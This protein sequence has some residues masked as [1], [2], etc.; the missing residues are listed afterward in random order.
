MQRPLCVD[1]DGT[2]IKSDLSYELLIKFILQKPV[3]FLLSLPYAFNKAYL[4]ERLATIY[5]I[6]PEFLPYQ[7][8][9]LDFLSKQENRE[10]ILV[11]GSHE[12]YAKQI[13][14]HLNL[15]GWAGTTKEINLIGHNKAK[16]L[17]D[18]YGERNFDY[19]GNSESDVPVWKK[20]HTSYS[21]VNK[22]WGIEGMQHIAVAKKSPWLILFKLLRVHQWSKNALV[23]LPM[24]LGFKLNLETL[25]EGILAFFSFSFIASAVYIMNDLLDIENDRKHPSKRHRPIPAGDISPLACFFILMGLVTLS[26]SISLFLEAPYA[27]LFPLGYYV[28][29]I[30]YSGRLKSELLIDLILLTSFYIIRIFYGGYATQTDISQWLINFSFFMFFSLA[31]IKRYTEIIKIF[32]KQGL[33]EVAGRAYTYDD[34]PILLCLGVGTGIASVIV[35]TL[36]F[37][38]GINTLIYKNQSFLWI[39]EALILTWICNIWIRTHR[40][41]VDDDPVKFAMTDK[42]SLIIFSLICLSAVKAIW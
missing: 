16:Y 8:E 32:K 26:F 17:I 1:L 10:I 5:N 37:Q 30:F 13:A 40:G 22:D 28:A 25:L 2:L 31:V 35:L 15:R 41:K 24:I 36:Y 11:T 21:V 39:I 3:H 33:K 29:N 34:A 19:I 9:V 18:R 7:P 20:A 23:F 27:F 38:F 12:N 6:T 14:L 4:K 42:F